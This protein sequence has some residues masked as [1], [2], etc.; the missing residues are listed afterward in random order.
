MTTMI[1]DDLDMKPVLCTLPKDRVSLDDIVQT[2]GPI[3]MSPE[4]VE[5]K[6]WILLTSDHVD[7]HMQAIDRWITTDNLLN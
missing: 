3:P 4:V 7:Y 5:G 2:I 6:E 1:I